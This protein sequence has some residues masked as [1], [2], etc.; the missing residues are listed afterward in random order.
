MINVF[1]KNIKFNPK[2]MEHKTPLDTNVLEDNLKLFYNE[3]MWYVVLVL[4]SYISCEI[5]L[6]LEILCKSTP[7]LDEFIVNEFQIVLG[8]ID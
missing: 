1:Q 3:S 4:D 5:R 8:D 7:R 2:A 6:K